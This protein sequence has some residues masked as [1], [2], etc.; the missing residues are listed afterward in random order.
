M[1]IF[2]EMCVNQEAWVVTKGWWMICRLINSSV[3][4]LFTQALSQY[5]LCA[6]LAFLY[7]SL[8]KQR[9]CQE[10]CEKSHVEITCQTETDLT[11]P[12]SVLMCKYAHTLMRVCWFL[13]SVFICGS[14]CLCINMQLFSVCLCVWTLTAAAYW[15]EALPHPFPMTAGTGWHCSVVLHLRQRKNSSVLVFKCKTPF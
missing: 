8:G 2:C 11:I 13:R 12:I 7:L 1:V 5:S 10:V 6:A 4:L 9:K 15:W 3:S 14:T